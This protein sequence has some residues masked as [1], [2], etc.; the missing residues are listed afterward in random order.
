LEPGYADAHVNLGN[1]LKEAGRTEEALGCYQLALWLKPDL[2]SARY[3]RALT[4]LQAGR[5]TEA[6]PEYEMRWR[7]GSM[8]PR[9]N[10]RPRWDGSDLYGKTILLWC[11]QGLGD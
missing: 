11:E 3:N 2:A 7:R 4:L 6:W 1:A 5:W 10:D 8:Q 9:H